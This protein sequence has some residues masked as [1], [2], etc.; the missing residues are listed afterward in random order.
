PSAAVP[1]M[2]Y[3]TVRRSGP[4]ACDVTVSSFGAGP[5]SLDFAASNF[6]VPAQGSAAWA[7][8]KAPVSTRAKSVSFFMRV[9]P[10]ANIFPEARAGC[11]AVSALP[12]IEHAISWF[13]ISPEEKEHC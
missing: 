9:P 4:V 5:L 8:A 11:K 6:Q 10:N 13:I 7:K 2:L 12:L 1:L 3:F